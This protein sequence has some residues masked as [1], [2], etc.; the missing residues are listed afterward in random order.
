MEKLRRVRL[1][2]F[3]GHKDYFCYE[4]RWNTTVYMHVIFD[5]DNLPINEHAKARRLT[6]CFQT[7]EM[8]TLLGNNQNELIWKV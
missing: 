2:T 5:M 4:T 3:L 7:S 6:A 8:C 1:V